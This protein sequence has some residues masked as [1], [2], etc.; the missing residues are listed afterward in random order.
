MWERGREREKEGERGRK[1]EVGR[2][3]GR[4]SGREGGRGSECNNLSNLMVISSY[5]HG[6]NA[7][8]LGKLKSFS[9]LRFQHSKSV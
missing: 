9:T 1:R 7:H 3:I 5:M 8:L 4:V 6:E 2:Q